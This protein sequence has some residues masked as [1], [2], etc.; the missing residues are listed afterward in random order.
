MKIVNQSKKH[1]AINS[2]CKKRKR[3]DGDREEGEDGSPLPKRKHRAPEVRTRVPLA[4]PALQVITHESSRLLD[5]HFPVCSLAGVG[6]LRGNASSAMNSCPRPPSL[7]VSEHAASTDPVHRR[8]INP[9]PATRLTRI[10]TRRSL[11]RQSLRAASNRA[12]SSRGP[13]P[14][15]L[16]GQQ[17]RVASAPLQ[18]AWAALSRSCVR[19]Y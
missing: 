6:L 5:T 7:W 11:S 17:E 10:W 12:A 8:C 1:R 2:E 4:C 9:T 15:P 16:L 19:V 13:R 3:I 18:A 14:A